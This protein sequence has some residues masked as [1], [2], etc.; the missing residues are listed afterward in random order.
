MKFPGN[1]LSF[2]VFMLFAGCS[3]AKLVH[4]TQDKPLVAGGNTADW[5]ED[6]QYDPKSRF[7]Y[8]VSNDD[9]NIYLMLKVPD[10]SVQRKILA[11]GLGV[12]IDTTNSKKEKF[13]IRYPMG[14]TVSPIRNFSDDNKPDERKPEPL[15]DRL[16]EESLQLELIGFNH[17]ESNILYLGESRI[18][19]ALAIDKDNAL[20]YEC[21][22]PIAYFFRNKHSTKLISIGF[23]TGT[24]ESPARHMHDESG[25]EGM[26]EGGMRGGGMRSGGGGIRG[27]GMSGGGRS[28]GFEGGHE[29]SG[30]KT[31]QFTEPS[32]IWIKN[33]SLMPPK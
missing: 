21:T 16:L 3:P 2:V 20:I 17:V 8:K 1:A 31:N 22:L 7:I 32:K 10:E 12:W 26:P 9:N 29:S 11:L 4:T 5:G 18:K 15:K 6:V 19:P 28:S 23:S 14:H 13:G 27:A 30:N 33:Y 24:M 25:T